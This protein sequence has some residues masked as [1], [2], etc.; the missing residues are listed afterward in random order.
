MN[1]LCVFLVFICL[2]SM[3]QSQKYWV[4]FKDKEVQKY[5][6]TKHLSPATL[7]KRH[8]LNL[9]LWQET[10]IPLTQ[11]YTQQLQKDGIKISVQSKWLN[12][13]SAV[14]T[15]KQVQI[16]QKYAFVR[17]VQPLA[18][19]V[20]ILN[21]RFNQK[22]TINYNR[23]LEQLGGEYFT[24]NQLDGTGV[25]IGVIDAGFYRA[26]SDPFLAHLFEDERILGVNDL[27]SPEK[28]YKFSESQT[29][30]DDH[31]T[32]VL[33]NITGFKEDKLQK[34]L[35]LGAKFYLARTD[36]GDREFRGEEDYWISA[37]EWMDS[38]GVRLV[39]TSLGYSDG[40]D[41]KKDNYTPEDMNGKTALISR[42]ARIAIEEK[43]LFLVV[44]AGNEGNSPRWR[45]VSAPA[46]VQG[47]LS[48]AANSGIGMKMNYS[49]LGPEFLDYVKP[50]VSAFSFW[51]TSFS[52]PLITGF[53]ACLLQEKP[54]V[55]NKEL[56]QVIQESATLYPYAN[57]YLGYGIPDAE[58]AVSLLQGEK[59]KSR[60][61][62]KKVKADFFTLKLKEK[63]SKDKVL[64]IIFF[65]KKDK[66]NVLKQG[67]LKA[68]KDKHKLKRPSKDVK[69]TTVIYGK[70]AWEIAWE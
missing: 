26:D 41:D 52:A 28:E 22:K 19:E 67:S 49:S 68:E 18:G 17:K 63:S 59:G 69:F 10:D 56:F 16:V 51:G 8:L 31:G 5:D 2:P 43:G 39:N 37:I 48:V 1:Y 46:D 50:N 70:Q 3:A 7:Q 32:E 44:S 35:A 24:E 60:F 57:N 9:P 15:Q 33:N 53:V 58:K 6:Y 30:S 12:A 54:S 45:L 20:H 62:F 61:V 13:V 27:V 55:S 14:L 36:H 25:L 23:S 42:A 21:T 40:F 29:S 34:G 66:H 4:F 65:H 47:V 11:A 64:R 38:L